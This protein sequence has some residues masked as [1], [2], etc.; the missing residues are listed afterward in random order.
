MSSFELKELLP[1]LK[2]KNKKLTP[3]EF[4]FEML[5]STTK[6][7]LVGF[8]PFKEPTKNIFE[9]KH[10]VTHASDDEQDIQSILKAD[11]I[12]PNSFL[13]KRA[14]SDIAFSDHDN[15]HINSIKLFN[16]DYVHNHVDDHNYRADIGSICYLESD[17]EFL[18]DFEPEN[19]VLNFIFSQSEENNLENEINHLKRIIET[20]NEAQSKEI[21]VF[22]IIRFNKKVPRKPSVLELQEKITQINQIKQKTQ[23]V[24]LANVHDDEKYK[25]NA[26]PSIQPRISDS[27]ESNELIGC[28]CK[29]TNCLKLY[30]ECFVKGTV[31]SASCKCFECMNTDEHHDIRN[32]LLMEHFEKGTISFDPA[33]PKDPHEQVSLRPKSLFCSCGKTG[34]NKKYCECF[35]TK[36]KCSRECKCKNCKNGNDGEVDEH[37]THLKKS[38]RITKKKKTNFLNN[39]IEKMKICNLIKDGKK[40]S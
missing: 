39:L 35:R 20:K 32:I 9:S 40:T 30:C 27:R 18:P 24:P 29:K 37:I 34:C 7:K 12:R 38:R 15:S 13:W 10:F 8:V 6:P 3:E 1:D 33:K 16:H 19:D 2:P 17:N 23:T 22:K 26:A 28:R 4:E 31:C 25:A 11:S 21:V 5:L 14:N 36:S